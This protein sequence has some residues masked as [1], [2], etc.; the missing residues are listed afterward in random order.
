MA[1]PIN[2]RP[3]TQQGVETGFVIVPEDGW[4]DGPHYDRRPV[5]L[6]PKDALIW[7]NPD[8]PVEEAAHITQAGS[9]PTEQFVWWKVR[10]Q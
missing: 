1:V 5:V 8:T 3:E 9:I 2:F 7:M 4:R 10:R 6:E